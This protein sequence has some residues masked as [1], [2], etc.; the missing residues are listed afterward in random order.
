MDEDVTDYYG[1]ADELIEELLEEERTDENLDCDTQEQDS[2][3]DC[4]APL[5][6]AN[7]LRMSHILLIT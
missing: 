1:D 6:S 2:I 4:D 3:Q 7:C 5:I